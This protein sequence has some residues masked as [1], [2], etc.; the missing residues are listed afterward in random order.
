MEQTAE[1]R[2]LWETV[3][4]AQKLLIGIGSEWKAKNEEEAEKIRRAGEKL[5]EMLSGRDYHVITTLSGP[6][7]ERL[8]FEKEHRTAPLDVSFTDEEWSAYTRWVSL[9][10]NRET[11]LLELGSGF[12]HPDQLR[13]PFERMAMVNNKARLVRVHKTLSQVPAE[14][15]EKAV[16]VA[17]NSVDFLLGMERDE[18]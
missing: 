12:S 16:S 6:D 14:L 9:T 1:R 15:K 18:K 17:E 2:A 5:K 7:L 10:L 8:P 13:W 3:L 11:A 4:G